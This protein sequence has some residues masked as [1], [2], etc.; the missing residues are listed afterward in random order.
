MKDT[1]GK[2]LDLMSNSSNIQE[3][4]PGPNEADTGAISLTNL[5]STENISSTSIHSNQNVTTGTQTSSYD[6]HVSAAAEPQ[7]AG[8]P[9]LEVDSVQVSSK[10]LIHDIKTNTRLVFK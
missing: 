2:Q 9:Q 4:I 8:A 5:D 1:K 10:M 6:H 3:A 7:I